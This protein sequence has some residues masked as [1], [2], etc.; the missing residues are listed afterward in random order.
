VVKRSELEAYHSHLSIAE[1]KNEGIRTP[2]PPSPVGLHGVDR[3]NFTLARTGS[4]Y[5]PLA[6]AVLYFVYVKQMR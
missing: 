1:V 2:T 5:M 6:Y 3:Y 4:F